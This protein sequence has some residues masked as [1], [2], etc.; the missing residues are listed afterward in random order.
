VREAVFLCNQLV[1]KTFTYANAAFAYANPVRG[2]VSPISRC[3]ASFFSSGFHYCPGN[4]L[5]LSTGSGASLIA[6]LFHEA[7][8]VGITHIFLER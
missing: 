1:V 7:N 6:E 3:E 5:I 4:A 2:D 8:K